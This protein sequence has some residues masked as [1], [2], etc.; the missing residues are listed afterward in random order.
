MSSRAAPL[1]SRAR[2]LVFG[3]QNRENTGAGELS[4]GANGAPPRRRSGAGRPAASAP[5]RDVNRPIK[6]LRP[7]LEDNPSL[8]KLLKSPWETCVLTR[9]P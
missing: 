1:S 4:G 9:G 8:R 2:G 5:L 7:R 3:A 6:D